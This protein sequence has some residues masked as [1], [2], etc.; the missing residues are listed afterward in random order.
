VRRRLLF[1]LL[2]VVATAIVLGLV[3]A[4]SP[5]TLARGVTIDGVEVGGLDASE[6]RALLEE[7]SAA[8]ANRPVIFVAGGR[9]FAIRPAELGVEPDWQAAVDS[10]RRQGDGFGPIRGF[11][12]LDV[13]VFGADVTPPTRVLN[14]ALEYKLGLLAG[15]INRAPR[16]AAVV[17]RGLN[18]VVVPAHAGLVLDRHAAEL[19]L[20]RALASIDR[21]PAHVQLPLRVQQPRVRAAALAAAA[22][23]ARTALSAPVRLQ[24]GKTRWLLQP[25]RIAQLL[26]LPAGGQTA[27][28]VG[29]PAADAWV[30]SLGRRVEK[31]AKDA[32]FAVHDGRVSVVPAKPGIRLDATGTAAALLRAALRQR[33]ALRTAQLPV[34]ESQAKLTTEA[35]RAMHITVPVSTYTTLYGGI[36]NRIHNVEL[37][38]HLVDGTLIAPG[39]TFSFN[40]TTG[41]RNAAKG[42]LEAPVIVNGELTTGLGGGVCQ[43][44][45]TVFNAAFEA[46]LEIAA[47]TNHA[48]YISHYPQGRDATVDYPTVD[49]KFVNDTGNW[50]LLRTFV[51]SSSLTVGLYGTPVHRKVVSSTS[52]LVARGKPPVKKTVDPTLKPGEKIVDD[53]G[54]PA[55]STSVTRDVYAQDGKL[56]YH[57]TWYS[58]YR[59]EP[60]LVRLGPAK[61]K[62]KKKPV[63]TTTTTDTTST[64]G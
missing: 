57:D 33:P 18:I 21:T 37:V 59:A 26:E 20:V 58:S 19:T 1:L 3:F 53:P 45:T 22:R 42:F 41:D 56:L 34:Q 2:S 43:V 4:G 12:R 13:Q 28:K 5:T 48:L 38:A 47:R 49:L 29:G 17:R 39:A 25:R 6:A 46:G 11:R 44:S 32:T 24:L 51:S 9:R 61:E 10:A 40:Q 23:Q 30:V 52:P 27:L 7:R 36:P 14:G 60:K 8:V 31:P 64:S 16:D 63:T 54:V 50:L 35:A 15:K 62:A 55:M